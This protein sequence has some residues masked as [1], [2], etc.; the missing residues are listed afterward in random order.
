MHGPLH[1]VRIVEMC[2]AV[3]GP[4]AVTLLVDQGA[5]AIKVEEPGFGDQG[6]YV[7]VASG[8]I[9][10]LFQ[11][12]NRGK[13]SVA[14]DCTDPRGREIVLGL[15]AGADVFVQNMRPGVVERLGLGY[16]DVSARNPDIVYAS[17]S[18]FGPDG[19]YAHRR[20][21]DSVIQAQSGLVGNQTGINDES[22]RFLRQAAADKITAY[23]ASQAIT[24]AL[25]ARERG[26]GGQHVQ[27]SMLDASVAF[28]FADAAAHE[29]ALDNDQRHLAQSFSAH[30]RAIALADG[31]VVVAAVTDSEFHGMASAFGVDSS[32]RRV[33]TMSDRQ[34]HKE[35][36]SDVFRAVHAAAAA[37]PL[38]EAVEALDRHQV[39]F[40]VVLGVED[41]AADPQAV[42]N[43][44]FTEHDHPAMGRVRQPRPAARFSA[45]PAELRQPSSP[46]HGQHTDEVLSELGYRDRI[47][48]LRS[49][50]VIK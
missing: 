13:R 40:G 9:S 11:T 32:D 26:A 6:R 10:A 35:Q 31:H 12:C 7:G 47:D 42:H 27:V 24:A 29:V 43:Q 48:Q 21:Y 36:A 16:D 2:V 25:L 4:L 38:A 14:V 46:I 41:V 15:A 39:P 18:G 23:T 45:T 8:G 17:L 50:G 30:Q 19:P 49:D 5:D 22:P 28:L 37:K 20:V 1:G 44:L 33:A 34:R 3:T